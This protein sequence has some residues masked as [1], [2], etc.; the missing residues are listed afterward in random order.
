MASRL[1]EKY[2]KEA[3]PA[4][5]K[6]F[7]YKNTMAVPRVSKVTVNIGLGEASQNVKLLDT[8]AHRTRPDCRAE[9]GDHA[10]QE[11][12]REFQDSQG[13]AHRLHGHAARRAH[14]RVSR[15]AF[16]IV[17]P[18]VRDFKGCRRILSTA[19]AITRWA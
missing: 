6:R 9:A 7:G 4:L 18:R 3:V 5:T 12:D 11:V 16:A 15:P 19:A 10:R 14:V 17:L 13:H 8:A 1:H 2:R